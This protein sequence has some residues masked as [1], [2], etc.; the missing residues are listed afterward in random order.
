M[1][2]RFG[3]YFTSM[4]DIDNA[5]GSYLAGAGNLMK[6]ANII[7]FRLLNPVNKDTHRLFTH[8]SVFSALAINPSYWPSNGSHS[9]N[10]QTDLKLMY[11]KFDFN[12]NAPSNYYGYPNLGQTNDHWDITPFEA[13]FLGNKVLPHIN[14]KDA[15]DTYRNKVNDFIRNEVEPWY[16]FLQNDHLGAQ[17]RNDYTYKSFRRAKHSIVTGKSVTPKTDIGEYVVEPNAAL[18]LHAGDFIKTDPGTHFKA[19][20]WVHIKIQY[21]ICANNISALTADNSSNR[22]TDNYKNMDAPQTQENS[23]SNENTIV[24]FPNPTRNGFTIVSKNQ[25]PITSFKMYSLKGRLLYQ[26]KNINGERYRFHKTIDK[27]IYLIL[28]QTQDGKT[29]HKKLIKQ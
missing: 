13:I 5:P 15:G 16:L 29:V 20:S 8:K 2:Q 19:G 26:E 3:I 12:P 23:A 28:V 14:L 11:N 27:G 1:E 10:L 17:A 21:D 18:I 25:I 4:Q 22:A 7:F 9:R 24:L 6:I